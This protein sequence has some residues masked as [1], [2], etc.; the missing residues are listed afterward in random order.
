MEYPH[1]I[2][3]HE[4]RADIHSQRTTTN[5]LS[6]KMEVPASYTIYHHCC[7]AGFK[8]L[9]GWWF[10]LLWKYESIGIII[11]NIW[12]NK[13]NVP[14]HQPALW[15]NQ[16]MGIWDIYAYHHQSAWAAAWLQLPLLSARQPPAEWASPSAAL[17]AATA[18]G[19]SIG[20][21]WR[22]ATLD[23]GR[24]GGQACSAIW[25]IDDLL[26][27]KLETGWWLNPTPLKKIRVNWDDDIPFPPGWNN[28]K[29]PVTSN[30][31]TRLWFHYGWSMLWSLVELWLSYGVHHSE[32]TTTHIPCCV[33]YM[34]VEYLCTCVLTCIYIYIL[35][36]IHTCIYTFT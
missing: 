5:V 13:S 8:T 24:N 29:C 25:C 17:V 16:P 32:V 23:S 14:N 31:T 3:V 33:R 15:I 22:N 35:G 12:E 19:Q 36:N 2:M 20:R 21:N 18:A 30:Q 28:K 4:S 9:S 6:V 27:G 10:Q 34:F 1:V 7:W 11:P 26:Q